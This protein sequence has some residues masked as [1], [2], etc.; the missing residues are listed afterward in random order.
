MQLGYL[1]SDLK[2]ISGP[3]SIISFESYKSDPLKLANYFAEF[4]LSSFE[5]KLKA[6]KRSVEADQAK[7]YL[8]NLSPRIMLVRCCKL[9]DIFSEKI[10]NISPNEAKFES[11]Y[12][13]NAFIRH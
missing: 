9:R 5:N 6:G 12:S 10:E 7:P 11:S 2:K 4:D 3:T 8:M 1:I 13:R